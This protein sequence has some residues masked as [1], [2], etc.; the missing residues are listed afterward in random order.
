MARGTYLSE[1]LTQHQIDFM[2]MLDH[3][4]M[5]IFTLSELKKV[6]ETKRWGIETQENI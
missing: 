6:S 1:N 3:R 4:E 2:L 5:D